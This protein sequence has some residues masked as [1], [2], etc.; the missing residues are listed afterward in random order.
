VV[1][2]CFALRLPA[3]VVEVCSALRL[4]AAV[5]EV[6]FALRLPAAVVEVCFAL[7]LP[8]VKEASARVFARSSAAERCLVEE[9]RLEPG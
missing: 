2:V 5:V 4:P 7:R 9:A 3:A 8:A 6:C 1:E